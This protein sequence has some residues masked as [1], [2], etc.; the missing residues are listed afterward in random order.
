[1]SFAE[2]TEVIYKGSYGVIDFIHETYVVIKLP[3]APNG[4]PPR[5]LVFPDNYKEIE[6]AKASTK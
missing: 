1:M 4:N 2:G 5:V 6:I 3:A